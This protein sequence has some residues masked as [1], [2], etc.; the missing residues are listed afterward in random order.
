MEWQ[1]TD[2]FGNLYIAES[3]AKSFEELRPHIDMLVDA[4]RERA[5]ESFQ[6]T[7]DMDY[8]EICGPHP[9]NVS[10]LVR[11]PWLA[12]QDSVVVTERVR[13]LVVDACNQRGLVD[14]S[15]AAV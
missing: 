5:G 15:F 12:G 13:Q 10:Y 11:V 6:V 2:Q 1:A 14:V 3:G 9:E 4:L 7:L 8:K